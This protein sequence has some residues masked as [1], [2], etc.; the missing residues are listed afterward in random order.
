MLLSP[1][2]EQIAGWLKQAY[3]SDEAYQVS[4]ETIDRSLYNHARGALKMELFE[5]CRC[6]RNMR[7]SR[8]HTQK[9]E[10]MAG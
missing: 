3:P 7:R 8:D 10:T 2:P 4:H 6:I 1:E 9:T 5:H